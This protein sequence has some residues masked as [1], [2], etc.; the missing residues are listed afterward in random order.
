MTKR[1]DLIIFGA[2][3]FT[4][5][6]TVRHLTLNRPAELGR[7]AIAGRNRGKLEAVLSRFPARDGAAPPEI[8]IADCNDMA[9]INAMVA[10]TKVLVHLAGPYAPQGSRFVTA[11]IDH[12]TDY[13]DLTG[14]TFWIRDLVT[15][16][17]AA[18]EAAGVK[19][20][21]CAGYEAL[22]FD[23]AVLKAVTALREKHGTPCAE[24]KIVAEFTGP[25]MMPGDALSGGTVGTMKVMLDMDFSDSL[26]DP[27]C[28]VPAEANPAAVRQ[29]NP[30]H[31]SA[32]FDRDANCFTAP[33]LPLPFI[34]VPIIH[35]SNALASLAGQPYGKRFLYNESLGMRG[36]VPFL[37][38]Q[39][40]AAESV[41]QS[42]RT[43]ITLFRGDAKLRR[44]F[45]KQF[46]DWFGPSSGQGPGDRALDKA[47]YR[48]WVYARGENAHIVTGHVVGQGHPG[49]RS[50]AALVAEAGV[51]LATARDSLPAQCGVVTPA[52][53]LGLAVLPFLAR[54]GLTFDY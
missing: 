45:M 23:L 28:L 10:S 2:T 31:L 53:G 34:N 46:L 26:D 3:G 50:T 25:L 44:H 21:P 27:A 38:A 12:G 48:L 47:G 52:A 33:L 18:A 11:C 1:Y 16:Q 8:V 43:M 29:A 6:Q 41:A 15:H 35:R 20:I 51:A 19:I 40:A 24:V 13:L 54:A 39:W 42:F 4:G 37:P 32:K 49:Y 9:S 14:E 17:H 36:M 7:W 30:Y 22:P 5:Q